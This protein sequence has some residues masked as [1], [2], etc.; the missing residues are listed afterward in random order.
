ME[1]E[2]SRKD[3]SSFDHVVEA[4]SEADSST[5]L[6]TSKQGVVLIP[7]PTDNPRDPLVC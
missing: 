7:Q 2:N 6:K 3:T 5:E 4:G 1:K